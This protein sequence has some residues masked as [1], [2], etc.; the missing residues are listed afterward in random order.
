M[1]VSFLADSIGTRA[2]MVLL[3]KQRESKKSIPLKFHLLMLLYP[4][5]GYFNQEVKLIHQLRSIYLI[6]IKKT[7]NFCFAWNIVFSCVILEGQRMEKENSLVVTNS[8]LLNGQ[9]CFG[10]NESVQR[11]KYYYHIDH[12]SCTI[13]LWSPHPLLQPLPPLSTWHHYYHI[14]KLHQY[15]HGP[16]PNKTTTGSQTRN[17]NSYCREATF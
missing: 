13:P 16:P 11:A 2:S 9:W 12:P 3:V 17:S 8:T 6:T 15:P 1:F 4:W 10:F 14:T 7:G 5:K